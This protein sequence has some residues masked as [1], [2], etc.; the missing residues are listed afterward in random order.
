M[1]R[2]GLTWRASVPSVCNMN[3]QKECPMNQRHRLKQCLL[4]LCVLGAVVG[5]GLPAEAQTVPVCTPAQPCTLE[6]NANAEPDMQEYRVFISRT[7]GQYDLTQPAR[8]IQHPGTSGDTAG[9]G[10]LAEGPHFVVITAVDQ[11]GNMSG[12]SN[13]VQF[14]FDGPPGAPV[15]RIIHV[16][17]P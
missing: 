17:I 16:T 8:V 12:L 15:L 6:W 14:I 9:I 10:A 5:I 13:E 4:I 3:S 2:Q 7:S 11:S 1:K